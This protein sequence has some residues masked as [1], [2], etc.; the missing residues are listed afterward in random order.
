[1]TEVIRSADYFERGTVVDMVREHADEYHPRFPEWLLSNWPTWI[2]FRHAAQ[3]V[4]SKGFKAY[5][6]FVIVNVLR[7]RADVN[8]G[9]FAMSNTLVPDLARLYNGLYGELFKT[10]TRFG[11]DIKGTDQ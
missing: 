3:R 10:S 1:M 2:E 7:W 9:K 6:A 5:S 8:G 4:H 11:K